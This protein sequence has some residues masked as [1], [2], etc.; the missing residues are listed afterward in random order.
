M[1]NGQPQ[2]PPT[3]IIQMGPNGQATLKT[4]LTDPLAVSMWLGMAVMEHTKGMAQMR[5]AQAKHAIVGPDGMPRIVP[6][7]T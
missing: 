3:I 5:E 1:T 7:A 2:Q 4:N 6:E